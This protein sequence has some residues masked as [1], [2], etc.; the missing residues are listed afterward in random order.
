MPSRERHRRAIEQENAADLSLDVAGQPKAVL[1]AADEERRDGLIE[2]IRI[3]RLKRGGY[4]YGLIGRQAGALAALRNRRA[5]SVRRL[6]SEKFGNERHGNH[7]TYQWHR[8]RG[9]ACLGLG[10]GPSHPCAD[11]RIEHSAQY[12]YA[13]L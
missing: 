1:V 5:S 3:E 12:G 13:G 8:G 6:G 9:Q 4:G 2:D 7:G 10:C 11:K